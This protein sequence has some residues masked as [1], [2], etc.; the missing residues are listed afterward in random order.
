MLITFLIFGLEKKLK[1]LQK[2][3]FVS[4]IMVYFSVLTDHTLIFIGDENR[5]PTTGLTPG[6]NKFLGSTYLL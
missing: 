3:N 1:N 4:F 6:G 2:G 5:K